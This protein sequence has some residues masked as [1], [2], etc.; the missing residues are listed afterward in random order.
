MKRKD[1]I[2]LGLGHRDL[3]DAA[4]EGLKAAA[5]AGIKKPAVGR[6]L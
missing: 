2:K 1:L 6:L 3:R 5:R 4:I